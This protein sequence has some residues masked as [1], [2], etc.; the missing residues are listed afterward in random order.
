MDS[1]AP[2]PTGGSHD[3][4]PAWPLRALED[5]C[6]DAVLARLSAGAGG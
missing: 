2:R 1:K 3:L 4:D 5:I 6:A